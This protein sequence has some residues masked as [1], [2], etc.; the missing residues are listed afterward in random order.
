MKSISRN[1]LQVQAKNPNLSSFMC[2][3]EAIK[4]RNFTRVVIRKK[5]NKL[6]SKDDYSGNEKKAILEF[7]FKLSNSKKVPEEC[8]K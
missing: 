6:V 4:H 8:Q 1:F 7:L 5:F 3:A 2:F